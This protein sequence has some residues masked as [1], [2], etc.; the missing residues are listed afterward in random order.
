M[1][2]ND[3]RPYQFGLKRLFVATLAIA[4]VTWLIT[5]H[6]HIALGIAGLLLII[7]LQLAVCAGLFFLF[8][9]A[10]GILTDQ[11]EVRWPPEV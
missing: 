11:D 3:I 4:A 9:R 8:R 7:L 1:D 5:Y 2:E 6:P 10:V